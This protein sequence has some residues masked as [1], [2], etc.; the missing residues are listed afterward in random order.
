MENISFNNKQDFHDALSDTK[1]GNAP[2]KIM[3]LDAIDEN[4]KPVRMNLECE[5]LGD[6]IVSEFGHSVLCRIAVPEQI[7][8]IEAFETI[9]T[10]LLIDEITFKDFLQGEKFF[11]KLK[12]SNDKYKVDKYKAKID[13]AISPLTPEKSPI[14]Q[15]STIEIEC[16]PSLWVNFGTKTAGLF[17]NIYNV[18][19]DGGSKKRRR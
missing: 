7:V 15:H 10:D 1:K 5:A 16:A 8:A 11:L 3:F 9:A 12:T 14:H 17:M 18:V 6:L 2:D 4:G 19:I 13:P